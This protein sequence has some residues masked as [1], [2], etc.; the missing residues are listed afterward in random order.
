MWN[1]IILLMSI[2][3]VTISIFNISP[4]KVKVKAYLVMLL[5][6]TPISYV[7]AYPISEFLVTVLAFVAMTVLNYVN[8]HKK[9]ESLLISSLCVLNAFILDG[10]VSNIFLSIL[11]IDMN[12]YMQVT[13]NMLFYCTIN[14][15]MNLLTSYGIRYLMD[16]KFKIFSMN[17]PK[18]QYALIVLLLVSSVSVIIYNSNLSKKSGLDNDLL[19]M[20]N[21]IL[22]SYGAVIMG[23]LVFL[24]R[25]A[26]IEQNRQYEQQELEHSKLELKELKIYTIELE[27][28]YE[29]IRGVKHDFN[30]ILTTLASMITEKDY[31]SLEQYYSNFLMPLINQLKQNSYK[32]GNLHNMLVA[33]V[34]GLLAIKLI[35]SYQKN[36]DF[37]VELMDPI[38]EIPGDLIRF[39]RIMG[40]LVDNAIEEAECCEHSYVRCAFV[41]EDSALV[42][43]IKNGCREKIP[44]LI[45]IKEKGFSTK[46]EGRG[47]GLHNLDKIMDEDEHIRLVIESMNNEFK[48]TV[49]FEH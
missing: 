21:V 44:S 43:I 16:K 18:I 40:I 35:E 46:G 31:K 33:E 24:I 14:V 45:Q 13:H 27:R 10:V 29:E 30:N 38:E 9:G 23:I 5:I 19:W 3:N 2:L 20:N 12:V 36:I 34:K 26:Q 1:I 37:V 49:V 17:I 39:C 15:V 7:I 47:Y 22:L 11:N 28:M 42:F 8:T 32:L 6:L 48:V 41:K 25:S 4:Y